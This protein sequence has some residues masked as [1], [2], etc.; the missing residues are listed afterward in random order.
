MSDVTIY[1]R[2]GC[3]YCSRLR[4]ALGSAADTATWRNIWE[5]DDARRYVASVNNG[6]EIVP[7]VVIAGS[8]HTNP[9]ADLVLEALAG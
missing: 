2:P 3:G 4:S 7:T 1:W 6:N 5:D 9:G 8:P